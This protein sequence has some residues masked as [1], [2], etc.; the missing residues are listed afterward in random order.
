[1]KTKAEL[2]LT[3]SQAVFTVNDLAVLWQISDRVR[4]WELIKYYVRTKR[5]YVIQRGVYTRLEEYSP[6]EAAVKLFSPAYISFITALALHG[7]YFQYT[8]EIHVAAQASKRLEIADGPVIVYHQVKNDILLNQ[9]GI[10]KTDGYWLASLE[11]AI[12]D[13]SYL[14]PG[15][16]FEHLHNV[17]PE[18]LEQLSGLYGNKALRKRIR[19]LITI[20]RE[21]A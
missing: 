9:Q 14:F 2:L 3:T 4:L 5:L 15:F 13:T 6:L 18:R 17:N 16:V 11:R 12:C 1:M 21:E 7:A 10:E 8:S 20:I 19:Q